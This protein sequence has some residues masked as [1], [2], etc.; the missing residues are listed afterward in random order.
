MKAPVKLDWYSGN[1]PSV[2]LPF[3]FQQFII[4]GTHH[5]GHISQILDELTIA[6]DYSGINVAFVPK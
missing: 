6:N 2:P 1:P 4:H 3:M 5:R